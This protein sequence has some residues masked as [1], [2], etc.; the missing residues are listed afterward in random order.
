[1]ELK[2]GATAALLRTFSQS[3]FD[4]FAALSG[5][6]NPIHVDPEF[7]ARTRF[8]RTVAHGMLL[9]SAICR[10]LAENIGAFEQREQELMFLTPTY[11]GEEVTICL[12]VVAVDETRGTAEILTNV[13][14]P[15]GDF[16]CQGRTVVA[17]GRGASI[18]FEPPETACLR[19]AQD[20]LGATEHKGLRLGQIAQTLRTFT[21]DDLR[22]YR[23]LSG[24]P[25]P[26]ERI[27][28]GLLRR[29]GS[30][31][32]RRGYAAAAGE[33]PGELA[34]DVRGCRAR[35]VRGRVAGAGEGP[36]ACLS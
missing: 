23:E 31:R 26:S 29:R 30:D 12:E 9:Y 36:G 3:D 11:T 6:D 14:R 10:V 2:P 22:E 32:D 4:R 15:G 7:A 35:G 28:G 24:D 17:V 16:A 13:M 8:G 27:P 5:D 18:D 21:A 33:G 19:S 34:R 1:M 25:H 20:A